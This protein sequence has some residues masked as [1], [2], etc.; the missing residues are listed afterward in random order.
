M[1][2]P[3]QMESKQQLT[4]EIETYVLIENVFIV[5]PQFDFFY[6]FSNFK[7]LIYDYLIE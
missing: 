2:E 6:D 7:N 1:D 5:D 3:N 4:N